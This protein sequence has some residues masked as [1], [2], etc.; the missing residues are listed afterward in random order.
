MKSKA[1]FEQ[2]RMKACPDFYPNCQY[3]PCFNECF[4]QDVYHDIS[5][6]TAISNGF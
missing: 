6:K 2:I 5:S 1:E 4:P 3:C